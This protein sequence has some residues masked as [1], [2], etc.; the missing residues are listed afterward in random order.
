[1]IGPGR[2][3]GGGG[4]LALVEAA[5]RGDE[6]AFGDLISPHERALHLHCYRLLG[7]L[8]DADDALQETM[9]NAW[10]GIS[11]YEPRAHLSSWLYRIATN[12]ALRMIERRADPPDPIDLHL[13]P[14]P[15]HL[16]DELAGPDGDPEAAAIQ[17]EGIGLAVVAA[18]QLLPARQRAVLVLRDGLGWRAQEVAELLGCTVAAANSSL[19]RARATIAR[20]HELGT[21]ARRHAPA[22]R[23]DE[24]RVV[25]R[26]R[27]A[28]AAVDVPAIV[29]LLTDDALMTMPPV[30]MRLVGV[31]PIAEFFATQPAGGHLDRI[32]LVETRANRQPAL[33]SYSDEAG[34]GVG[35]A[36]GVMVLAIEG[37]RIAG[38]TGFPWD[39][40]LFGRLGLP[41]TR[42]RAR[43][44][45]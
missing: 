3:R 5:R 25:R 21:L 16:L 31:E 2:A 20:E 4:E 33:V 8:H 9:L 26:F 38:F 42:V 27:E 17:A 11:A 41:L 22:S 43:P 34:G 23:G 18:I 15:D 1:M 28:W 24:E 37:S 13:Q 32:E 40:D 10:R 29:T 19:Q 7:S 12:V 14:Y 39:L 36:Y 45:P 6:A 30:A 35:A 44:G